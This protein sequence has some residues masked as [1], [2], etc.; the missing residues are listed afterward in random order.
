METEVAISCIQEGLLVE[1]EGHH[2]TR[3]TFNPNLVLLTKCARIKTEPRL[4][5]QST[6]D[7]PNMR[8]IHVRANP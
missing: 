3:K 7:W 2:P 6:N 8:P 5:E 1:G 4:R